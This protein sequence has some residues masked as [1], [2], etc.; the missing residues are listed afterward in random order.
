MKKW[1]FY[2]FILFFAASC[3]KDD[4]EVP[5]L[6][7]KNYFPTDSGRYWIYDVH[8]INYGAQ[9]TDTF[10]QRKEVIYDTFLYQNILVYELYEYYRPDD[11]YPWPDQP[12][13]VWSFTTDG[14]QIRIKESNIEYVRLSFPLSNGEKWN[15]NSRNVFLSDDYTVSN[16]GKPFSVNSYYFPATVNII[17]EQSQN[18]VNKDY[19]NRMYAQYTG[20][21]YR[22]KEFLRYNT[23]PQ[24][25]GQ[26]IV[27]FGSVVEETLSSYGTP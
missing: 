15:G 14:N 5:T 3:N 25:I 7:G 19:R 24:Y 1:L 27:E 21:I 17:E 6:T 18:L 11:T 22:K 26:N 13:S 20:M 23:D 16:F 12:D 10:Y 4:A 2:I 8:A 9:T